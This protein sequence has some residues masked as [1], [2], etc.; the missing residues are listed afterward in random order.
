MGLIA[1]CMIPVHCSSRVDCNGRLQISC[2]M[3]WF[4][5]EM[6]VCPKVEGLV[7]VKLRYEAMKDQYNP[8]DN[9]NPQQDSN[10]K[11]PEKER[12]WI[13]SDVATRHPNLVRF[14]WRVGDRVEEEKDQ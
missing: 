8:N 7:R 4:L 1:F 12:R 9:P 6:N 5:F 13:E 14:S 10:D 11:S 2:E 3:R